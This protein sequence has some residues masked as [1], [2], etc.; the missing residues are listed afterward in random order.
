M[1]EGKGRPMEEWVEVGVHR[2][3]NDVKWEGGGG[4]RKWGERREEGGSG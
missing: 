4:G 3:M 2:K 1:N